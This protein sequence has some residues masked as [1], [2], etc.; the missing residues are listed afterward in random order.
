MACA[1][2]FFCC[3]FWSGALGLA[4][5]RDRQDKCET[6]TFFI[7]IPAQAGIQESHKGSFNGGILALRPSISRVALDFH[8]RGNDGK[9]NRTA[10]GQA[11]HD[12]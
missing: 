5:T 6:A 4:G 7:V 12:D 11:G 2:R 3:A 9:L 10:A 1:R 8:L